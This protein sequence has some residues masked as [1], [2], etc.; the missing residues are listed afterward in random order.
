M[1]LYQTPNASLIYHSDTATLRLR[2]N[3]LSLEAGFEQ[4]YQQALQT[5]QQE[6]VA[7]LLL[8]LKR[9]APPTD[10][11][12]Q[13]LLGPL[14]QQ[15]STSLRYPIFIAAV[16]SEGQYQYQVGNLLAVRALPPKQIEF[17][18]FTCRREATAWLSTN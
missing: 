18:Y 12:E 10:D 3:A 14:V 16:V 15:L 11:A 17:N 1:T 8:D 4:A 6:Q 7:K 2:Y 5:M 13:W 9:N